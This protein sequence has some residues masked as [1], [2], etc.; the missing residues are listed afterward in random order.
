MTGDSAPEAYQSP[1]VIPAAEFTSDG[2]NQVGD[3]FFSF[4]GGY[5]L[6]SD[7]TGASCL[8]A[9]VYLPQGATVTSLYASVLDNTNMGN[10]FLNLYRV[11]NYTADNVVRMAEVLTQDAVT[12]SGIVTISD[13]TVLSPGVVYPNF[14][15]YVGACLDNNVRLYAARIYYTE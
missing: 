12:N 6:G 4:P 3:Y 1:L 13:L 8:Q 15:Y 10:I 2:N 11:D 14:S 9:P 7:P 5:V